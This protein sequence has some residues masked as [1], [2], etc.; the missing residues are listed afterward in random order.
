MEQQPQRLT[1][2]RPQPGSEGVEDRALR[3]VR[4]SDFIGQKRLK[5]QLELFIRAACERDEPLDHLLLHGP[6]GLGKTTLA[7]IVAREMGAE[8][9]VTSGP[10]FQNSAELLSILTRDEGRQ[11]L[12]IDEV[13][14]LNRIVEEHLYPAMEDYR[15]EL[16]IDKGPAARHYQLELEPFTLIGATTRAGMLTP[17]LRSRFGIVLHL[18]FYPPD[19]LS[20]IIARSAAL[21]DL[22][23]TPDGA[24]EL[25]RR[26]RGT[27]RVANRLL[28]RVR[29]VAQV[30]GHRTVDRGVAHA[31]LRLLEVDELG[32][33]S[34]DRAYLRVLARDFDGGPVGLS[35]LAVSL[36]EESDTLEDVVEPYLIQEGL[37]HRTPR[38]RMATRRAFEHLE[39]PGPPEADRGLF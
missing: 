8:F 5:A 30:E 21:L 36:G 3:P 6:P 13:H 9:R 2:P 22:D 17:A 38:G 16:V 33:E 18:D 23:L 37:V 10:A 35:N 4:F 14:R 1:D 11:C 29:D 39:L 19:E 25:A 24:M 20:L 32:L 15:V 26:S 12:F 34:L 27:P 31:A 28:R 7:G